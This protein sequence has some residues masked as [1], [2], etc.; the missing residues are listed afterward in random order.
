M[1]PFDLEAAKRGAAVCT[2]NG[3]PVRIICFDRKDD[4][5]HIVALLEGKNGE[6][7]ATYPNNGRLCGKINTP[8]DLMMVAAKHEGWVNVYKGNDGNVFPGTSIFPSEAA[9]K[10]AVKTAVVWIP[11]YIATAKI[12]W[13]E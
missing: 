10:A 13:G 3:R 12:E 8:G 11:D 6:I 9:A 5:L 2:R 1:K 7:C 4:L